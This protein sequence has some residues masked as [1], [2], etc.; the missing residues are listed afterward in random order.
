[1]IPNRLKRC[2][3]RRKLHWHECRYF[4][5]CLFQTKHQHTSNDFHIELCTIRSLLRRIPR[6]FLKIR[7]LSRLPCTGWPWDSLLWDIGNIFC[8]GLL[9]QGFVPR[10]RKSYQL[11]FLALEF[12]DFSLT[13]LKVFSSGLGRIGWL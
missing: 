11:V 10:F 9:Y 5:T 2:L 12:F 6:S 7:R 4:E 13:T 8:A 1:M 3:E